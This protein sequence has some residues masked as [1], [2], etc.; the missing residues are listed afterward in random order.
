MSSSA[1][2]SIF[3][4]WMSIVVLLWQSTSKILIAWNDAIRRICNV[5]EDVTSTLW[6]MQRESCLYLRCCRSASF[7]SCLL[8]F[9]LAKRLLHTFHLFWTTHCSLFVFGNGSSI[10]VTKTRE[11]SVKKFNSSGHGWI[12]KHCYRN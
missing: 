3:V 5:I 8:F 10:I 2:L 6:F 7:T 4:L 11:N 9:N 1:R 12:W